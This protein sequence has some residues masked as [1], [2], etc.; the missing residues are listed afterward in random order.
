LESQRRTVTLEERAGKLLGE[1]VRDVG[2]G[3]NVSDRDVTFPDAFSN[4]VNAD[5]HVFGAI[6]RTGVLGELDAAQVVVE[7]ESGAGREVSKVIEESAVPEE[8]F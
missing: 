3:A 4:G 5:V 8:L 1:E 6:V 7:D 2:V